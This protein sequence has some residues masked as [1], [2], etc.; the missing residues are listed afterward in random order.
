MKQKKFFP[1]KS[2]AMILILAS[3]LIFYHGFTKKNHEIAKH[4]NEIAKLQEEREKQKAINEDL[5]LRVNSQNDP[6]WIELVLMRELGLVPKGKIKV[7]FTNK[8]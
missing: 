3:F 1:L 2:L 7:H 6:S 8:E 5:K 4:K